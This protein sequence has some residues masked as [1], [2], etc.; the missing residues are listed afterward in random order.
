M[1][2]ISVRVPPELYSAMKK[3]I[4][5]GYFSSISEIVREAVLSH[6]REEI[7]NVKRVAEGDR[8]TL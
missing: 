8:V 1:R 5:E 7:K 3:L 6:L 4:E 2:K